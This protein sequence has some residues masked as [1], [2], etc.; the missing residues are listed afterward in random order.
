MYTVGDF[1]TIQC[2]SGSNPPPVFTW[3]FNPQNKSG[4]N[5]IGYSNDKSK[6]VFERIQTEN[7]GNYT[8][9]VNNT[10]RPGYPTMTS[11]VSVY[12]LNSEGKYSDCN[13]C[14]YI[15]T[16]QQTNEKTVCSSNFWV[17]IAVVFILLSAAFA[18]SSI[19]MIM[20]RK[21]TQESTAT[22]NILFENKYVTL[23]CSPFYILSCN[24]QT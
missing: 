23:L 6:L 20:Q 14:G 24:L 19:V 13:Q 8:C 18:V 12:V 21:R 3:S 1:L 9:T 16:C 10:E 5:R 15:E 4:D 17:P 11:F 22:N 7:A 2:S